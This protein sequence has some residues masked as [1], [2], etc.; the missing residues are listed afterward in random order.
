MSSNLRVSEIDE[1]RFGIRTVRVEEVTR[2]DLDEIDQ[3]CRDNDATLLIARVNVKHLDAVQRMED[4]G[5]RLMDTLTYM[6]FRYNVTEIP[7]RDPSHQIRPAVEADRDEILAIAAEAFKGYKG[8]YHMDPRLDDDICDEIYASWAVNSLMD[9]TFAD[10][11]F[12]VD[13]EEGLKGFFT[14]RITAPGKHG[15]LV[16]SGVAPYAQKQGVYPTMLTHGL[17]WG[18]DQGFRFV[19]ASTQLTNVP[20]LKIFGRLGMEMHRSYYTFHKW[21]D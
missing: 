16:L 5:Y 13:G 11:V 4:D 1:Q 15:E 7:E 12:V 20:V 18:R 3:F 2:D 17:E 8:H 10:D 9:K 6:K 19:V 14:V 21:F